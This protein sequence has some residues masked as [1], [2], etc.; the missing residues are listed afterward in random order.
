M[1]IDDLILQKYNVHSRFVE[2]ADAPFILSLRIDE[3]L[4]R[5]LSATSIDVSKQEKWLELYKERENRNEE[6]YFIFESINGYK[7]GLSRIYNIDE[8]SFEI[9]SWLFAHDAPEGLSILADLATRD[10]AFQ[11]FNFEYCRFEVRKANKTV[12]NYHRRFKPDLIG[13][14]SEN[15]YFKL[16]RET[17]KLFRNKLL[18]LYT[19]G[20][21]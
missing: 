9:G 14:D 2:I 1:K 21:K 11:T 12:S 20:I 19:H 5:F 13:E 6:F 4:G 8:S 17:Y 15:Y 7:Y 18:T 10:Y 16:S 3:R